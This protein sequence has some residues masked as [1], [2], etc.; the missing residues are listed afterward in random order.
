MFL[1]YD[2]T[3]MRQNNFIYFDFSVLNFES[4]LFTIAGKLKSDLQNI[5]HQLFITKF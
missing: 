3:I 4:Q 5:K 2:S 1:L